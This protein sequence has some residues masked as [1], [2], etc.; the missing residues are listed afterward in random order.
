MKNCKHQGE[1]WCLDC[2]GEMHRDKEALVEVVIRFA[3]H[4]P[5]CIA[6]MNAEECDCGFEQATSDY[7]KS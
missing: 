7:A 3:Q 1:G 4:R 2:V 5:E 6:S